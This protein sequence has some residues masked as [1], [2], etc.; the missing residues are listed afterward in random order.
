[1]IGEDCWIGGSDIN[2]EGKYRWDHREPWVFFPPWGLHQPGDTTPLGVKDTEREGQNCLL[3][4]YINTMHDRTCG[5]KMVYMCQTHKIQTGLGGQV[6]GYT[7]EHGGF[8]ST[9]ASN[10]ITRTVEL[11][12][13]KLSEVY[14]DT[15][16]P[17]SYIKVWAR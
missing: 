9:G 11:D 10:E 12:E 4:D 15:F 8:C 3:L 7:V 1:M 6:E 16:K 13:V 5:A 17:A 14:I 2:E